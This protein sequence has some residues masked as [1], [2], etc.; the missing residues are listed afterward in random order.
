MSV[1][2]A[3]S[4]CGAGE[5]DAV[6]GARRPPHRRA[7]LH[8]GPLQERAVDVPE[9]EERGGPQRRKPMSDVSFWANAAMSF[10]VFST[11]SSCT[12][13]TGECM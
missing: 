6:D 3:T 1:R 2:P 7:V 10:A 11:S 13:S 12:I 4:T 5:I 8:R 9:Q